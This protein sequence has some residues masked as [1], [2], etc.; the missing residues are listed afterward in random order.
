V[1]QQE[2]PSGELQ[3]TL[4]EAIDMIS[5]SITGEMMVAIGSQGEMM[6]A[7]GSQKEI[8]GDDDLQGFD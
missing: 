1:I 3:I 6:V 5:S 7:I 8:I 4:Q 2:S